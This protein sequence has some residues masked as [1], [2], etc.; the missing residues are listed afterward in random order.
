MQEQPKTLTQLKKMT[1][2]SR[3]IVAQRQVSNGQPSQMILRD[4]YKQK[5]FFKPVTQSS[6][7]HLKQSTATNCVSQKQM[8]G[9]KKYQQ[10]P[11][12][13][14]SVSIFKV[15]SSCKSVTGQEARKFEQVSVA[16]R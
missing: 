5:Q 15:P 8:A 4:T 11:F 16:S 2:K 7:R 3:A 12:H 10:S 6:L 1:D 13:S 14:Q 9:H